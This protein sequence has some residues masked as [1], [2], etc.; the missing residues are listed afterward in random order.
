MFR[1]ALSLTLLLTGC[2]S[3]KDPATT[4]ATPGREVQASA[5]PSSSA[6]PRQA[7]ALRQGPVAFRVAVYGQGKDSAGLKAAATKAV[8]A[9][10]SDVLVELEFPAIDTF[11]PPSPDT[12][13]FLGVGLSPAEVK[14]VQGW[15]NE[16]Q[17]HRRRGG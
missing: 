8:E 3:F 13:A 10:S 5:D 1:H 16:G 7:G 6:E 12:L 4:G 17:D 15:T 14:A 2:D 9:H 11:A